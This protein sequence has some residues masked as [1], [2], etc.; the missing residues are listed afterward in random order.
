MQSLLTFLLQLGGKTWTALVV[1]VFCGGAA[2]V[3]YFSSSN[4][5]PNS[6]RANPPPPVV[7][8]SEQVAKLSGGTAGCH[9]GSVPVVP[10]ANA[11]LA[12]IPVVAAMLVFSSRRLWSAKACAAA[13]G[14]KALGQPNSGL[15]D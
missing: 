12:L 4:A 13:N 7:A 6:T 14:A 10:E 5:A 8:Q 2:T 1:A 3:Y 15:S 11:G 9:P